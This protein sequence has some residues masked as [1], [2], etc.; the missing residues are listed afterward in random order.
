VSR[1]E[2]QTATAGSQPDGGDAAGVNDMNTL[3]F[4]GK[5]RQQIITG[6]AGFIWR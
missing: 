1:N 5:R 3:T 2:L 6:L 4:I